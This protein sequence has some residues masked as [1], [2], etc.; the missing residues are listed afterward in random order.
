MNDT[1]N[2]PE[3]QTKDRSGIFYSIPLD[4]AEMKIIIL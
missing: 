2:K 1:K 3:V 4:A